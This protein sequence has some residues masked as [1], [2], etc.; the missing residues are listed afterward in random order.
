MAFKVQPLTR[1]AMA[2]HGLTEDAIAYLES[3]ESSCRAAAKASRPV[4]LAS[5]LRKQA[6]MLEA[7]GKRRRMR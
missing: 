1:E 7:A 2:R 4:S 6:R 3:L 5:V